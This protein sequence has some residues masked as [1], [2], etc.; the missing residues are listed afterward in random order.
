MQDVNQLV[1]SIEVRSSSRKRKNNTQNDVGQ[2]QEINKTAPN[3]KGGST[4]AKSTTPCFKYGQ[5][6]HFANQCPKD[7]RDRKC[8]NHSERGHYAHQCPNQQAKEKERV[9]LED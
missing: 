6:A 1:Q 8:Y 3:H 7:R 2:A 4:S 5:V 9:H